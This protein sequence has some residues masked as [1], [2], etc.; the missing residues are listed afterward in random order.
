MLKF[1]E[2]VLSKVDIDY[3]DIFVRH[4]LDYSIIGGVVKI[5]TNSL[6]AITNGNSIYNS[7]QELIYNESSLFSFYDCKTNQ[8]ITV[9]SFNT[10]TISIDDI[11][12]TKGIIVT[13]D[14]VIWGSFNSQDEIYYCGDVPEQLDNII[15]RIKG[16]LDSPEYK[17]YQLV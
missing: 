14:G 1:K 8:E 13:N 9:D 5:V 10:D 6:Y 2:V 4:H 11:D 17:V 15:I 16:Y 12:Y 3:K 7:L